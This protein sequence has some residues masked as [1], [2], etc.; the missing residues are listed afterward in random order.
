MSFR[1]AGLLI[2]ALLLFGAG[3][4]FACARW[5]NTEREQ[6]PIRSV[7]VTIEG[8]ARLRYREKYIAALNEFALENA[9]SIR[10]SHSS[11][12][13]DDI[14]VQMWRSDVKLI[15]VNATESPTSDITFKIGIYRNST[16]PTQSAVI[17]HLVDGLRRA[18]GRVQGARF[19]EMR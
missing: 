15:G 11:P 6:L 3:A 1:G 9:F 4:V 16:A 10:V 19:S 14:L 2:L 7:R 5:I 18:I 13:L 12:D 17:D 8:E